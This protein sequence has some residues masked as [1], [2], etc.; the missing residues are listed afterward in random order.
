MR[1]TL[2]SDVSLILGSWL[3]QFYQGQFW[4]KQENT[5]VWVNIHHNKHKGERLG[6][7]GIAG[8]CK[9]YLGTS[10][11]HTTRHT[12]AI[13]MEVAGAKLTDI[14]QRLGHK[15]AATT[16]IYM[17]RLTIDQNAYADKLSEMLGLTGRL[18]SD[19]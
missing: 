5:P 11:V 9:H 8:I 18:T 3:A 4:S 14:Q 6:Y 2:S 15:N 13:L 12:F 19:D 1:D 17:E 16:G 10:K 7:H